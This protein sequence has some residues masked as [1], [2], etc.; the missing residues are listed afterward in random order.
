MLPSPFW[1][2]GSWRLLTRGHHYWALFWVFC[3]TWGWCTPHA[4]SANLFQRKPT[5]LSEG[6][7]NCTPNAMPGVFW[8]CFVIS[9][10]VGML[11]YSF[12]YTLVLATERTNYLCEAGDVAQLAELLSGMYAAL[13][14]M[15][16]T[17]QSGHSGA[18]LHSQHVLGE[19]ARPA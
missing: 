19:D 11:F 8:F 12:C 17:A 15:S 14:S 7:P 3:P 13:G 1:P 18:H 9:L 6:F 10:F 2:P 4:L 16:R 5:E